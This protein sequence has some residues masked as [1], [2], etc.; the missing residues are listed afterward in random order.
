MKKQNILNWTV[1]ALLL[2]ALVVCYFF[3]GCSLDLIVTIIALVVAVAGSTLLSLQNKKIK[4]LT[5]SE[6]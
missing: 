3:W 6:E 1:A 4:E 5:G 2:I